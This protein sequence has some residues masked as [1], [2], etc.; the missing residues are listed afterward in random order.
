ME[1]ASLFER[2][3]IQ[4]RLYKINED[5]S[6]QLMANYDLNPILK[7]SP[8]GISFGRGQHSNLDIIVDD[9]TGTVS[10]V[11]GWIIR[12]DG[13]LALI[14]NSSNGSLA[15]TYSGKNEIK[16]EKLILI[17]NHFKDNKGIAQIYFGNLEGRRDRRAY[18]LEILL[19]RKPTQSD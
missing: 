15:E 12:D 6:R 11:H 19:E 18:C 5:G 13:N 4:G 7:K 16:G 8:Q 2:Y 10:R 3:A 9:P 17:H 1:D 14:D